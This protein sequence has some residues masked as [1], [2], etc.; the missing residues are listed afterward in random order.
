MSL[1]IMALVNKLQVIVKSEEKFLESKDKGYNFADKPHQY[2]CRKDG[3]VLSQPIN[4]RDCEE[5]TKF[6]IFCDD[7][8]GS[9]MN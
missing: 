7:Q 9:R 5:E 1:H 3:E 2:G 6:S 4:L 8:A